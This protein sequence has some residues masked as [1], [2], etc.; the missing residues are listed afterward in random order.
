VSDTTP[1]ANGAPEPMA[2]ASEARLFLRLWPFARPDLASLLFTLAATPVIA[3]AQL[4]QPLI[5]RRVID[6]NVVPGQMAGLV[7]LALTYLGLVLLVFVLE[8]SYTLALAWAGDRTVIRLRE[9]LYRH[10]LRLPQAFFDRQPAGRLLTRLTSDVDALGEVVGSGAITIGLDLLIILG[11]VAAMV[12]LDLR[13]T[14]VMLLMAPPLLLVLDLIRRKLRALYGTMR[15]ALAAV[16]AFLAE[17]VDGVEVVQLLGDHKRSVGHFD[18]L[19]VNLRQAATRSNYYDALLFA[20]VDG[21]SSVFVAVVVVVGGGATSHLLGIDLGGALTAGVV[22]AFIDY[23]DRLFRPLR[24]I[25]NKVSILQ[26]GGASLVRIF[27]LLEVPV[28]ADA[29]RPAEPLR[30][31]GHLRIEGL[32]FR[33]RSDSDEVLRGVEL[34]VKPGEVVALVGSSGSGKTTLTRLLDRSYTGYTGSIRLDGRELSELAPKTLRQIVVAVRQDVQL[35]AETLEFNVALGD[36]RI[37]LACRDQAAAL[38]HADQTIFRLGWD[39]VLAERG[40][41]LSVGEGQLLTFARAMAHNPEIVILDEATASVDSIT[42]AL[43]QDAIGR[44]LERKTVIVVA[45]RLST[46]QQADRIAV[47]DHGR[48]VEVGTHTELL[49]RGGRYAALIAAGEASLHG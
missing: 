33:Y 16:N 17:R 18:A 22:V 1:P 12:A 19:N 44:I 15:D 40:A 4:S 29:D 46:I 45:H 25:S 11:V 32:R 23:L 27:G 14:I 9:T 8:A 39:H 13:L 34:E 49:A 24:D 35:F 10:S 36:P 6:E 21:A 7:E 28:A 41:N 43:V 3:I 48:V 42:E 31:A 26:R 37:D 5:L 30:T 47:M 2:T 20:V 38:V